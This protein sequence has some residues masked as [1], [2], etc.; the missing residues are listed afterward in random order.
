MLNPLGYV[1]A[2]SGKW[3]MRGEPENQDNAVHDGPTANN[4]GNQRIP[5][6][7]KLKYSLTGRSIQFMKG[8]VEEGSPSGNWE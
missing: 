2:H 1:C 7:H 6:D 4:E 8:Q 5:G 3:H